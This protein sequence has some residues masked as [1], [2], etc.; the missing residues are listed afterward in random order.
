MEPIHYAKIATGLFILL[1]PFV[2]IPV[3]LSLAGEKPAPARRKIALTTAVAVLVIMTVSVFCGGPLLDFFGITVD[4][5]RIAGG[6]LILLMALNMAR[7]EHEGMR[8]SDK[9]H[10]E[11]REKGSNIAVV[12]LA[13]PLMAGPAAISAAVLYGGECGAAGPR[14]VLMGMIAALCGVLW[15]SMM[16]AG[17]IGRILGH[18]G[19]QILKRIMGLILLALAVEFVLTGISNTF[20]LTR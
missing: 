19:Q 14:A 5:F 11:A 17:Q 20:H 8:Y 18:T 13:I 16:L 12:P 10:E 6:I 2:L 9:E 3:F 7:G 4:D 1:N 15:L